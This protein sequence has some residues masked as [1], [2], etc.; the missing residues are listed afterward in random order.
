[1]TAT[2][3]VSGPFDG[4]NFVD[5]M[6]QQN[7][8]YKVINSTTAVLIFK[9][10]LDQTVTYTQ[11]LHGTGFGVTDDGRYTGTVTGFDAYDLN[12]PNTSWHV[13]GYNAPLNIVN[14]NVSGD[15]PFPAL[16]ASP[17]D[18]KY[19]GSAFADVFIGGPFGDVLIGHHGND[20]FTGLGGDD[21]IRGGR[22]RDTLS[23]NQGA[24][25]I[26]GGAGRDK[27]FGGTDADV[28]HGGRA[29]DIIRGGADGD[30]IFG[31]LGA[32]HLFGG[33]GAD[34][35]W[36]GGS[37]DFIRGGAGGDTIYGGRDTD[38]L[39][40][41]NGVDSLHGGRGGDFIYGGNAT[42]KLFGG[43]GGDVVAGGSGDDFIVG[44]KGNDI[45]SGNKTGNVAPDGSF[46]TFVFAAR[47]GHDVITDFEIGF[48]TIVLAGIKESDVTVTDIGNNVLIGVD[49]ANETQTILVKGVAAQFDP[50]VDIL[51]QA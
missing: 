47:F 32:D 18:W 45:L 4:P 37:A 36:G 7:A 5:G 15:V 16:L 38:V 8:E 12:L 46:D 27:I 51:F 24:D 49:V 41:D 11:V 21:T 35:I 39:R 20:E 40:G 48:D 2:I 31:D 30:Q 34:S 50:N 44:G 23:G 29:G 42:D 43:R 25:T 13:T 28:L 19:D 9:G 17:I 6:A 33:A 22:G 1:M 10:G 14:T 26:Y 3:E